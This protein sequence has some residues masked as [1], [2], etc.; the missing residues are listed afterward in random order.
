MSLDAHSL[1][2]P[3]TGPSINKGQS[4]QDYGTPIPFIQAVEKRFGPIS[5][6]LAASEENK[7]SP[8]FFGV[9][10]NSLTQPWH[11]IQGNLWL[12]PPFSSI[13]PWAK[14]CAEESIKGARILFLV[15]SSTGANWFRDWVWGHAEVYFLNGRLTFEG[16]S[17]PY[18]K[19]LILA[20]YHIGPFGLCPYIWDWKK[21]L[22]YPH[23]SDTHPPIL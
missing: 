3:K 10:R 20:H 4:N 5:F 11:R 12:N 17:D 14:K 7:K 13:T 8:L 15:P 21:D 9:I 1:L 23:G 22:T 2:H 6:D 18:P 16:C 19:D